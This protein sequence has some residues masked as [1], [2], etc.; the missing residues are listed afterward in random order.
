MLWRIATA[1]FLGMTLWFSATAAAPA[2]AREFHLTAGASAWL[3]MA[4]QAGFVIGT[5]ASA[6]LNLAD[7]INPRRLFAA[8]CALGALSNATIAFA[9]S[10]TGIVA[11]RFITGMALA[12]VYPPGMKIAAGWFLER[13]GWALGV[14]VG[15]LT[16]GSAFP[17]LV[18][19]V[20]ADV[21]WRTLLWFSSALALAGGAIV[22]ASVGDGPHV[23]ASAPFDFHAVRH[24]LQSRGVRLA[25]LGYLGHMWSSM[26][27]GRGLES[28]PHILW[29]I[30][31]AQVV[32]PRWSRS[33]PSDPGQRAVWR[34]VPGAIAGERHE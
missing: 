23:T 6:I 3:T 32:R 11:L 22:I 20:A 2:I 10:S 16:I 9:P 15:A 25:T 27:C 29:P 8:G 4:V 24:V 18:N 17:H 12:C 31:V 28:M 19:W 21:S 1:Q 33:W 13:R 34:Q 5:L 14:V 26:R 7:A 30:A